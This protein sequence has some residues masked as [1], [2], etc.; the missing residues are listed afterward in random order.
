MPVDE[1]EG[2]DG[3]V[4]AR[5]EKC[6]HFG[7]QRGLIRG[8]MVIRLSPGTGTTH[9]QSLFDDPERDRLVLKR[10]QLDRAVGTTQRGNQLLATNRGWISIEH[11]C[12]VWICLAM[13]AAAFFGGIAV[14]A[15][16]EW[17]TKDVRGSFSPRIR[18]Q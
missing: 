8:T 7:Q 9:I 1:G 4:C 16:P 15:E 3:F 17:N 2:D 18:L 13:L 6:D 10:A 14:G 5:R 12:A 11:P